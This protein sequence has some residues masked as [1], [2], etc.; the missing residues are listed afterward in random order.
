MGFA[1]SISG[2]IQQYRR[3]ELK[4]MPNQ[5]K[6]NFCLLQNAVFESK[7]VHEILPLYLLILRRE[8]HMKSP[9]G[10]GRAGAGS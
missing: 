4:K 9:M 3:S 7:V 1:V 8:M 6:R 5:N 10:C 2:E